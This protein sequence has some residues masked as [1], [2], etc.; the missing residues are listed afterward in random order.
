MY[1]I[2][3]ASG[4]IEEF[5]KEKFERSLRRAGASKQVIQAITEEIER[6]KPK[7]TRELHR[8]A[9]YLLTRQELPVAGRYN[10]KRALMALGPAGYPFEEYIA[11]VFNNLGYKTEVGAHIQGKCVEHEID[12]IMQKENIYR[13]VEC[14]F[15]NGPGLKS[16]VKVTL[17]VHAR[18]LDLQ[19]NP[20]SHLDFDEVWLVT[21]TTF[22]TQAEQ[23]AACE[24]I[25]LLSWNKGPEMS[26]AHMI[27]TL[28]LHPVTTLSGLSK[29]HKRQCIK[30]G[31]L[32]C[33]DVD[34]HR[35]LLHRLKL[36]DEE[37]NQ[38]EKEAH[39]ICSLKTSDD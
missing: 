3:K 25:K 9:Q 28:G 16:D 17:Y 27:D 11:Q 35:K 12:V 38:L 8:I 13:M 21:N 23:Y 20:N 22:T 30:H 4:K 31:F 37:I 24:N 18:F 39:E 7:S 6:I 36:S 1:K 15:H 29:R 26:L 14:K 34:Q 10:L 33:K 32:L 19:N 2:R 5:S